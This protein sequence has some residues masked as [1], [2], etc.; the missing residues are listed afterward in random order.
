[1]PGLQ[2]IHVSERGHWYQRFSVLRIRSLISSLCDKHN[3]RVAN[4]QLKQTKDWYLLPTD[5]QRKLE[6]I[7]SSLTNAISSGLTIFRH[8][9]SKI[10]SWEKMNEVGEIMSMSPRL[11]QFLCL[12]NNLLGRSRIRTHAC[13]HVKSPVARNC[14]AALRTLPF[15]ML[16]HS[17]S[18]RSANRVHQWARFLHGQCIKNL[19]SA[20]TGNCWF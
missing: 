6:H 18:P 9:N 13:R 3:D 15:G 16:Y 20:S 17:S 7:L 19:I 5:L 12:T 2:L 8:W 11:T 14:L 10:G 4:V 1:M